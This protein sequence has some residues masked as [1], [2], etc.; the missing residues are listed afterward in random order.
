MRPPAS[1]PTC[2]EE[3][4]LRA[5]AFEA[6]N[7]AIRNGHAHSVFHHYD[8]HVRRVPLSSPMH[9]KFESNRDQVSVELTIKQRGEVICHQLGPAYNE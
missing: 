9:A 8:V 5:I 6:L 2:E 4:E 3:R 1:H 7:D